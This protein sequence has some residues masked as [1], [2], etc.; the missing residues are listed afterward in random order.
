MQ[1]NERGHAVVEREMFQSA[2]EIAAGK[3][4]EIVEK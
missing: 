3:E 2:C 1:F 4:P